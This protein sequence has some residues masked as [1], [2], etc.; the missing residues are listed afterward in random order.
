MTLP[1][2]VA[3]WSIRV[4]GLAPGSR[5][6]RSDA[7]DRDLAPFSFEAT[8]VDLSDWECMRGV[9]L[10]ARIGGLRSPARWIGSDLAHAGVVGDW[11]LPV[12]FVRSV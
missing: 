8:S 10:Y 3:A 12:F 5:A 7:Y 11:S 6:H 2:S 1:P 9:P 4:G